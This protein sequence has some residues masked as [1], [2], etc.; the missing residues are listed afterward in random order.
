MMFSHK[1]IRKLSTVVAS[2][3][4]ELRAQRVLSGVLST[5]MTNAPQLEKRDNLGAAVFNVLDGKTNLLVNQF[6]SAPSL[7][8]LYNEILSVDKSHAGWLT[9]G[10]TLDLLKTLV[11]RVGGEEEAAVTLMNIMDTDGDGVV[12]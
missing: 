5:L 2:P 7:Q 10:F 1:L 11:T 6:H 8:K 12:S 4:A 3:P 9:T